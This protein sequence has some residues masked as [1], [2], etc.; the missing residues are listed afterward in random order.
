MK[1]NIF[2]ICLGIAA[3]I[4]LLPSVLVF[5]PDK[6]SSSYGIQIPD[7]NLE[8]LLRHRAVLFAIIGGIMIYSAISRN[9]YSLSVI[10]GMISMGSFLIL[11]KLVGG[12]INPEL[13]KVMK[14]DVV[15]IVVLLIAYALYKFT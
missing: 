8:L 9:Y 12:E 15:G 1:E 10:I 7:Q 13:T 4:N 6:I 11:F 3:V 14:V 2:R 5:L